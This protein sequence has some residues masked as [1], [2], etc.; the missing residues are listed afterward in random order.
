MSALDFSLKKEIRELVQNGMS[1]PE[2][3][4]TLN[5]IY[6]DLHLTYNQVSHVTKDLGGLKRDITQIKAFIDGRPRRDV[7]ME[8]YDAGLKPRAIALQLGLDIKYV[9]ND[10]YDTKQRRLADNFQAA[11][12]LPDSPALRP[13]VTY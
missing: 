9:S 10:I 3:V 12:R 5:E 13:L 7:V 1:R 6:P 8:L 4:R 2:V 11:S